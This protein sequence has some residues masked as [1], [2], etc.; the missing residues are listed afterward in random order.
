MRQMSEDNQQLIWF[1]DKVAKEQRR[2]KALAES[3]EVVSEKLRK[4]VE[5]NRIVWQ[6]S[7][8]HHEQ[9]KEEM[10][11][12]EQFFKE[13]LQ[14]IHKAREDSARGAGEEGFGSARIIYWSHF[15][16]CSTVL[17]LELFPFVR[18]SLA[19]TFIYIREEDFVKFVKSQDKEMEKFVSERE[20]LGK[21]YEDNKISM[22][23]R[24][25]EEELQLEKDF[26]AALN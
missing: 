14:V 24:H 5:E 18:A 17:L 13:Q 15:I 21:T 25:F 20:K 12:Q 9:N 2:S 7:K 19:L 26:D 11:F 3:F 1:K 16:C 22:K 23:Q 4:T 6:R 8:M 10:D